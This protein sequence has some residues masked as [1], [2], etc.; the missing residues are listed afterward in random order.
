Q[1]AHLER[2]G[3]GIGTRGPGESQLETDR[4]L[5]RKRIQRLENALQEVRAQRTVQRTRR[6]TAG[7][8]VVS[9]VGYTNAGKSTLF[10]ALTHA[11]VRAEDRLFSTLDP[12]TRRIVLPDGTFALLTDTVGFIHKLPPTLVAAFH[13]TLEEL[14]EATVLLHVV[15]ITHRNAR[16]QVQVVDETLESLGLATKPRV[17]A[18]NKVDKLA[19]VQVS[20]AVSALGLSVREKTVLVSAAHRWGLDTL[21]EVL[22]ETIH[23]VEESRRV[24]HFVN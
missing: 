22:A 18:L 14:E 2:L 3:G 5:I 4:R 1:W 16:Q 8:P 13:A 9:L 10:N 24:V 11:A 20:P 21:C 6:R 17:L 7:L 12:V 19:P 23:E 15:D